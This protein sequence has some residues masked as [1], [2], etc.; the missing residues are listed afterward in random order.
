MFNVILI[1]I[2]PCA[3]LY[4]I[5]Q[6]KKSQKLNPLKNGIMVVFGS[7]GHTTEMLFLLKN[8]N[9]KLFKNIYFVKA[10][11]DIDS[12]IRV[13][14]FCNEQNNQLKI[15]NI[16]WIDIP[17]SREV[18]QSYFSSN[19]TTIY[20]II[21]CFFKILQIR[22]ID[23]LICNGPGT[24]VP[25]IFCVL[26]N[27]IF[28]IYRN[29]KIIFIESWCRV[30]SLSLTGKLIIRFVDRFNKNQY[31][32][33]I[34]QFFIYTYLSYQYILQQILNQILVHWEEL[35]Y[36]HKNVQYIGQLI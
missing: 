1:A 2:F 10:K 28:F 20:S 22:Q 24:C 11:S 32:Y 35:K 17:R 7:G 15:K 9:F 31:Y 5:I 34:I 25:L 23:I 19:F 3:L 26:F 30:K 36:K 21:F 8:F 12:K 14:Q 27:K 13:E 18:G 16:I 33:Y 29:S 6:Y 4:L